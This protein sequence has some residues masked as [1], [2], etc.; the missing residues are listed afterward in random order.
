EEAVLWHAG[1]AQR[2]RDA[3]VNMSAQDRAALLAFLRSL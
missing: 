2:A 3:F 1:E